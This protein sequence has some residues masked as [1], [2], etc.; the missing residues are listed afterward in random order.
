MPEFREAGLGEMLLRRVERRAREL[1][2]E[3]LF[4]LTTRTAHWFRERGFEEVGPDRL[5][6]QKRELY[7][8]QRRSKVLMKAI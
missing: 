3:A 8:L 1:Y 4:V 7:N 2:L 6:T 5:P